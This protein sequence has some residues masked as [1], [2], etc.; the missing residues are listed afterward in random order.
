MKAIPRASARRPAAAQKKI[1]ANS[2]ARA[3]VQ[4]GDRWSLL[5]M[6]S[7]FLGIHRFSEWRQAIGVSSN[8]LSNRLVRLVEIGCLAKVSTEGHGHETYKLTR[9]GTD[10]FATAL[11]FWRF[12]R[13]W[14]TPGSVHSVLLTHTRCGHTM[15]PRLVCGH[16]RAEVRARDVRYVNGPGMRMEASPPP[17]SSRRSNETLDNGTLIAAL[18]GESIDYFG[19]R[20]TQL[21]LASF[22]LGD[23]RFEDIR[24]RW[25]LAPNVLADR[26]K[27]LVEAGMLQRRVYESSY[28]RREYILTP[29]GMD[30]YPIVLTLNAWGDRWLAGRRG[31]PLALTHEPCGAPL[32]P[33]VVCD[34]C[35]EEVAAHEV[36]FES[37]A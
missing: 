28:D 2:V 6:G 37:Q 24:L 36:R 11:M 13:I 1:A 21:V 23:R 3:L 31:S 7:A 10:L 35:A 5:I 16:C 32:Q 12:N 27:L 14:S 15:N 34:G 19:D 9:M 8:I 22:F 30:V 29:K 26:L 17:K 4:I 33:L 18:Y 25:Q 20:F